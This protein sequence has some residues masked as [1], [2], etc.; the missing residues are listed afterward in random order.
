M[1]RGIYPRKKKV[2]RVLRREDVLNVDVPT[3][4]TEEYQRKIY[5]QQLIAH[6]QDSINLLREIVNHG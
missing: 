5:T 1:P 6:I 2:V 3:N 4:P